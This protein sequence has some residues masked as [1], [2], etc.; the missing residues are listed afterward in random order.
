MIKLP[1]NYRLLRVG[2]TL[3]ANDYGNSK[4]NLHDSNPNFPYLTK[5]GGWIKCDS[6]GRIGKV[7]QNTNE[8]NWAFWIRRVS[9]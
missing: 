3:Q 1:R 5:G 9:K 8:F 7:I 6:L 2:E 4:S